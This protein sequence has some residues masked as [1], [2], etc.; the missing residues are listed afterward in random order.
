MTSGD[1]C[2]ALDIDGLSVQ[3]VLPERDVE[4]IM[5]LYQVHCILQEGCGDE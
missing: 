4:L 5:W 1:A 3:L 2:V